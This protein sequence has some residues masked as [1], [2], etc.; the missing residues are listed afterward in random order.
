[1]YGKIL[2]F[3]YSSYLRT[4]FPLL[5]RDRRVCV[6]LCHYMR[7][8]ELKIRKQR[9]KLKSQGKKN[10]KKRKAK[11]DKN[12]KKNAE[13]PSTTTTTTKVKYTVLKVFKNI[14]K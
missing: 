12:M 1:M 14:K 4:T 11:K 13:K 8:L 6:G 5:D 3:I 2:F 10:G 9:E 7:V